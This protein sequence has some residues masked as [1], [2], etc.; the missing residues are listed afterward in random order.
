MPQRQPN[1]CL[2]SLA[3]LLLTCTHLWLRGDSRISGCLNGVAMSMFGHPYS[4]TLHNHAAWTAGVQLVHVT[5]A[6]CHP[7]GAAAVRN[8][9]LLGRWLP[10]KCSV[11]A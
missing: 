2:L 6:A 9:F 10:P 8:D 3:A 7:L 4:P 11:W 1:E 5:C